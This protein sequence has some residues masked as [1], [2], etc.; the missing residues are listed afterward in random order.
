MQLARAAGQEVLRHRILGSQSSHALKGGESSCE[1]V[2]PL[3][4][5]ILLHVILSSRVFF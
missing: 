2:L 4:Y 3:F 5:F 1:F